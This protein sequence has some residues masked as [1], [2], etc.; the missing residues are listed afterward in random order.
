MSVWPRGWGAAQATPK[1]QRGKTHTLKVTE[2]EESGSGWTTFGLLLPKSQSG[3]QRWNICPLS[4]MTLVIYREL[5]W[6][7]AFNQAMD[8]SRWPSVHGKCRVLRSPVLA[9]KWRMSQGRFQPWYELNALNYELQRPFYN[10]MYWQANVQSFLSFQ[11]NVHE[12]V[13]LGW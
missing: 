11:K 9:L 4:P 8:T 3:R 10:S 13:K 5:R 1:H 12:N 7:D 2:L 6:N